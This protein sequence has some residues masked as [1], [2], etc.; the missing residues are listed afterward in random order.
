M[1]VKGIGHAEGL[2]RLGHELHETLRSLGGFREVLEIGF[3]LD[4]RRDEP[5]IK[6]VQAAGTGDEPLPYRRRGELSLASVGAQHKLFGHHAR[7]SQRPSVRGQGID[8]HLIQQIFGRKH[9]G[10]RRHGLDRAHAFGGTPIRGQPFLKD[11][12]GVRLPR[13]HED[14]TEAENAHHSGK[15]KKSSMMLEPS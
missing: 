10:G 13:E 2:P 12:P 15:A 14:E 8:I 11:H 5:G 1:R 6:P 3:H 7:Q 9:G 4:H